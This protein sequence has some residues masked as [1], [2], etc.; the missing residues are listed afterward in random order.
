VPRIREHGCKLPSR[1]PAT[2][3]TADGGGGAAAH[4]LGSQCEPSTHGTAK[5]AACLRAPNRPV[6]GEESTEGLGDEAAHAHH[7]VKPLARSHQA[8]PAGDSQVRHHRPDGPA[9][10]LL[11]EPFEHFVDDGLARPATL[12]QK[13]LEE[14]ETIRSQEQ[15]RQSCSDRQAALLDYA[16]ALTPAYSR[17][18][19]QEAS[20]LE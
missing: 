2:H 16:H 12:R 9:Q 13:V 7:R 4:L 18:K 14:R 5:N 1:G 17:A 11:C 10:P 19:P 6:F 3:P 20:Q 15:A 8:Q